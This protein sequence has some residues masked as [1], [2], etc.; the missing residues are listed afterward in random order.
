[1][2]ELVQDLVEVVGRLLLVEDVGPGTD[3]EFLFHEC[4][5]LEKRASLTLGISEPEALARDELSWISMV[6]PSLTLRALKCWI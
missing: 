3:G 1:M 4:V 2:M 5:S 6:Y